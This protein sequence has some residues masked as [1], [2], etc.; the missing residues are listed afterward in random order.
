MRRMMSKLKKPFLFAVSMIPI[1]AVAGV[2]VGLYQIELYPEETFAEALAQVGSMEMLL[3]VIVLQTV[4]YALICG[5][6]GYLLA[7]SLGLW[8]PIKFEKKKLITTLIISLTGGALFSLDYWTFG[9]VYEDIR[10]GMA[11]GMTTSGVLCAILYGGIIEELLL[12][13]FFMS[14]IAFLIWKVFCRKYDRE[15]IPTAVFVAANII[16]ALTFAAGHL[17]GT[18]MA[19]GELTPL[20]LLRCFLLNGSFGI[21]FG[22]V[23]RKYGIGYA[24]LTHAGCHIV[25]KLIWLL[26]I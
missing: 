25:S 20:L 11:A 13:L 26:F 8:K 24:M 21:A 14:L 4:I 18:I 9:A 5:F 15:H 2:F 16:A 7:D 19:F 1:A 23:Y 6:F 3:A 22:W 10:V 17:P 12:R